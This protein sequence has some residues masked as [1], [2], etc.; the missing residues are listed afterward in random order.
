MPKGLPEHRQMIAIRAKPN[1]MLDADPL[2]ISALKPVGDAERAA[3]T[4]TPPEQKPLIP[5]AG[6]QLIPNKRGYA[7]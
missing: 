1:D 5:A 3:L 2:R 7:A 6:R 4:L